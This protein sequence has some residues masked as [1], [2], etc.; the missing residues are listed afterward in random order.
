MSQIIRKWIA[1]NAIDEFKIDSSALGDGL[2]GGSGSKIAIN[3]GAGLQFT[4]GVLEV[5]AFDDTAILG[6]ISALEGRM[7]TAEDAIDAV[8]GRLDTAE[9]DI[10]ALETR[11]TT[12]EG[13]IDAVEGR[14]DTAE[15]AIAAV[16]GEVDVLQTTVASVASAVE[17]AIEGSVFNTLYVVTATDETN[18]YVSIAGFAALPAF[19]TGVSVVPVG[20]IE[21]VNKQLVGATGVT[22]DFD[23]DLTEAAERIVIGTGVD[24]SLSGIFEE[25]D[26]LKI[27]YVKKATV[28]LA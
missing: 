27:S 23:V 20:G 6:A 3:I 10:D 16:E 4:D 22:A 26:V 11:M 21:Q 5:V 13:D 17:D 15:D 8:E 25:G 7:D 24:A 18:G 12:A 14:M 2:T 1:N 19:A 28:T 9:G